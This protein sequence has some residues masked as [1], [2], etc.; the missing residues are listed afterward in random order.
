[1]KKLPLL[2]AAAAGYVLG[3]RAGRQRYE[4]IAAGARKIAADPRVQ[5]VSRRAQDAAAQQ[6]SAAAEAAKDKVTTAAST[7]ADKVRREA[8]IQPAP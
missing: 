6:A 7:A 8:S 4:Q 1:V 3:S 2:T 5:R